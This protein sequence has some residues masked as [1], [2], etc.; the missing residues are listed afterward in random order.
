[1]MT[2]LMVASHFLVVNITFASDSILSEEVTPRLIV[3]LILYFISIAKRQFDYY[4]HHG[5]RV[6]VLLSI[7]HRTSRYTRRFLYHHRR[8]LRFHPRLI[9]VSMVLC[10]PG[11]S[12]GGGG[13]AGRHRRR[14]WITGD[15]YERMSV[16]TYLIMIS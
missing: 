2:T 1:M 6:A 13:Q 10:Y 11:L 16:G 14:N 12:I 9:V 3:V 8:T 15:D 5:C 7:E 4:A